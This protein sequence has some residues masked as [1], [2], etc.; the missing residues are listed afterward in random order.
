MV[1]VKVVDEVVLSGH[2]LGEVIG[3]I[4][5]SSGRRHDV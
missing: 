5:L 4:D 3:D 1:E 2:G